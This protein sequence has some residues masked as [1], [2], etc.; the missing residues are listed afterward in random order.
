MLGTEESNGNGAVRVPFTE[1]G[2]KSLTL[3]Q[4]GQLLTAL[5]GD[6]AV[7]GY[8]L[9]LGITGEKPKAPGRRERV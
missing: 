1:D 5:Y 7:F 6:R 4:A 2:S 3:E 9:S 8:Y